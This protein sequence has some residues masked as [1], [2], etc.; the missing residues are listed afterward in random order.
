MASWT[1]NEPSSRTH[2]QTTEGSHS[3]EKSTNPRVCFV[4]TICW[5]LNVYMGPHIRKVCESSQVTLVADRF[6]ALSYEY[7][8]DKISFHPVMI[9]RKIDL[10]TDLRSLWNLWFF[11]KTQKFDC[12]HSIMPKA[13]LLAMLAA[14]AAGVPKRFHTFTGQVWI[15]RTGM[16][17][18]FL[19]LMD[20]LIARC[21]THLLTDSFSQRDFLIANKIVKAEKIDVLGVGSIVG[22][23]TVRFAPNHAAR[24]QVRQELGIGMQDLVFIFLGRLNKDKGVGDLLEAFKRTAALQGDIHLVLVGPDEF[25]FDSYIAAM[26]KP[27]RSIIHRIDFTNQPELYLAAADV[28]CLP[29]YREGFGNA[30]IEAAAIGLPAIASRI[31]GISDAVLDGVT[32]ILHECGNIQEMVSIMLKMAQDE[33]LRSTMGSA[34]RARVMADFSEERLT[35]AFMDFYHREQVV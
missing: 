31:Y 25:N 30:L 11:F 33:A 4:S 24:K 18:R 2:P 5:P 1:A 32:G 26:D 10:L 22:V 19:R 21:A 23:N 17:R 9:Q 3:V 6:D 29:S 20:C 34:A 15:T 27:L 12:V 35:K 14:T 16:S 8:G 13:G 7:F 28:F